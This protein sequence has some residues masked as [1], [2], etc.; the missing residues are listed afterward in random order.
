MT[1]IDD[2]RQF[3]TAKC[4]QAPGDTTVRK[5]FFRNNFVIFR[6]RSKIIAFWYQ[7][8]FLR[9]T[10]CKFSIFVMITW[11]LFGTLQG[12]KCLSQTLQTSKGI[13]PKSA[14]HRYH[15]FGVKL[16]PVG[17]AQDSRRVP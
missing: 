9:V 10:I 8:I 12:A 14:F 11:P 15:F 7:W 16:F 17:C 2:K 5:R 4:P 3:K 1:C 13:P 6:R